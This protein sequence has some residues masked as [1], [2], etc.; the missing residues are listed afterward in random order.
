MAAPVSGQIVFCVVSPY[1]NHGFGFAPAMVIN[2]PTGQAGPNYLADLAVMR[3][4]TPGNVNSTGYVWP[5]VT[6]Y[7]DRAS[8][9]AAAKV[10]A[11]DTTSNVVAASAV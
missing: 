10:G 4:E 1:T 2:V 5:N 6:V 7:P 9:T 3:T 8:A 11:Q